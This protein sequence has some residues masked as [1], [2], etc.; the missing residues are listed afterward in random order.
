MDTK[1]LAAVEEAFAEEL[2]LVGN[3]LGALEKAV[4]AKMRLWG[5]GLLQRLLDKRP[6]GYQG[7]SL[8]CG[9][10]G[11]RRFVGH[12]TR[13][14]HTLLGVVRMRRAYYPCRRCGASQI[15]YDAASG[16]GQTQ[17]SPGLARACSVL[18][19]DDSFAE[20]ARKVAELVGQPVS[21]KTVERL[22]EQVGAVALRQQE[23]AWEDYGRD[24]EPPPAVAQPARLYIATDGTTLHEQDGWHESKL[25]VLYWE[26][27]QFT[28][29]RRYVGRLA[30]AEFFGQRVWAEAC[31]CGLREAP[32]VVYLGDG[33]GW[34]R[35]LHDQRFRRAEFIIDWY[36]ASEHV[37]DCGKALHGEGTAATEHWVKR[38][39][40]WLWEGCTRPLLLAL[41]EQLPRERG[42][43]RQIVAQLHKYITDNEF[44]MR[45]DVF[46]ARDYDIGSGA[47]EG[48]CKHVVGKRLKQAGMIWSRKGSTAIQAL[49]IT[50]LNEDW[51]ALWQA[52]PLAAGRPAA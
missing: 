48:G 15:P 16:L 41:H 36:H 46:R 40:D 6:Q 21:A 27:E 20:T 12:R 52:K 45:Y 19:V 34:I 11:T 39:L 47:V 24:H 18:A 33:A 9:C 38:R 30:E 10:G 35:R 4:N 42:E 32:E 13:Q 31:R 5:Q 49:R 43:K 14:V 50:W 26:D 2:A 8:A 3:D 37:W 23:Q 25:A 51:E 29:H 28:R 7:S 44:E 1:I 22:A 17:I